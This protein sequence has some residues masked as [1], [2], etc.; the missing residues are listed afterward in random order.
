MKITKAN[1]AISSKYFIVRNIS[2]RVCSLDIER[3]FYG[4]TSRLSLKEVYINFIKDIY[5]MRY[6]EK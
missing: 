6:D 1:G 4:T 2:E 3:K 5:N